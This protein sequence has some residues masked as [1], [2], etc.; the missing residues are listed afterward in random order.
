M[1]LSV[2]KSR[3]VPAKL[4]LLDAA[5]TVFASQGLE[6]ATTR[7]IAQVAGV[8]EVTLFRHFQSKENLQAAVLQRVFAQQAELLAAHPRPTAPAGLRADLERISRNYLD[9]LRQ[10]FALVRTLVGEIH[11]HRE[12]EKQ[13]LQG[14][15]EPLRAEL[16]ATLE[17]ARRANLIRPEINLDIA[18]SMLPA[19]IFTDTLRRSLEPCR[20]PTHSVEEHLAGCLDVFLRGI[21]A[22]S[23]VLPAQA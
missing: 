4:R 1:P 3:P 13:V 17:A 19:M 16:L 6:G 2:P 10:N 15:F 5:A 9:A 21:A 18:V 12:H 20:T 14:V 11:R 22:E 8:N 23:P 7:Q